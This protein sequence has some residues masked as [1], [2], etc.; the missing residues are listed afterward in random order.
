MKKIINGKR[1]DTETAT[2]I[3][4]GESMCGYTDFNWFTERLYRT[5]AGQFFLAGEGGPMSRWSRSIDQNSWSS[6]SGIVLMTA[7]EARDWCEDHM[8]ADEI[9][10]AG[11]FAIE[12]G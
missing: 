7:S 2:E 10:A 5:K 4:L 8:D 12:E 1:Y 11:C 9:D 6:G 3:G